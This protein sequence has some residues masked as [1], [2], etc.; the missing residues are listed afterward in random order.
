[1]TQERWSELTRIATTQDLEIKLHQAQTRLN[2]ME[3]D[4]K[5]ANQEIAKQSTSWYQMGK[6]LEPI[7]QKMQDVGKQ[8]ESVGKNLTTKVTLPLVGIGTAA[9]KVGSDFQAGMSEVQAISGATG[10]DLKQLETIAKEMGSTTKFSTTQSAE[11]LKY[12][13]LAGWDANQMVSALPGVL[14]LAAA[15]NMNLATASDIVTDTM[16]AFQMEASEAGKAADIFAATSSKSNTDV[17]QLGEAM[18]YAGAAA[19]AAGMGLVQTNAVCG[20]L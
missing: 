10:D 7:G 1:M 17:L 11:G 14:D 6:A 9:V 8:M 16:S 20:R 3:Q 5:S 13:A 19:N 12:M 15:A 4:L 2:Y 18:K